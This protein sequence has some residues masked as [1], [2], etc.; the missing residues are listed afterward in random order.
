M[1]V[2]DFK[3]YTH[4]LHN[5]DNSEEHALPVYSNASKFPHFPNK[6]FKRTLVSGSQCLIFLFNFS[7]ADLDH[8]SRGSTGVKNDFN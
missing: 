1:L 7:P 3:M 4:P 2:L 5:T 6:L 8:H